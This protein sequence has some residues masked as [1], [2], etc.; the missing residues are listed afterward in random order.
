MS[1]KILSLY[2][3]LNIPKEKWPEYENPY[4]FAKRFKK[5]TITKDV[6]TFASNSTQVKK[7]V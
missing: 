1:K 7:D 2:D 5:C 4:D 3:K 6:R